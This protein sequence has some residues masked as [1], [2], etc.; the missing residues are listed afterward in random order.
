MQSIR[1]NLQERSYDILVGSGMLSVSGNKI[2]ALIKGRQALVV[3]D[4]NVFKYHFQKLEESLMKAGFIVTL[5]TLP[6]GEKTKSFNYL[7]EICHAALEARIERFDVIIAFGGGVIGDIAGFAAGI[8]LRGVQFVQIPTSLMAQV[9]SSV[10][11]KTGINTTYGKNL[12]GLFNQPCLVLADT[13]VLKTLSLREFRAGYAEVVKYGLIDDPDFFFWLENNWQEIFSG[14]ESLVKAIVKSCEA[15]SKIVAI[16]EHEYG[17]RALLNLGHTFGHAL[18]TAVGYDSSCLVHGEAV[19]IGISLAYQLSVRLHYA[20]LKEA[21][22]VIEHLKT[23]GLPTHISDCLDS[24]P[25]VEQLMKAMLQDKKNTNG[26]LNFIL[27]H[28]IGK[29]FIAENVS[30]CLIENFLEEYL[31]ECR[32]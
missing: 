29:A 21:T 9:D 25:S 12:L 22:R 5:I 18:E 32:P 17:Q 1:I 24:F 2:S 3:T 16:D 23:V 27:T 19:S 14:G 13:D 6:V 11:G 20:P 8:V 28:G 4:S 15:K 7:R 10:G 30:K 31:L 26:Q